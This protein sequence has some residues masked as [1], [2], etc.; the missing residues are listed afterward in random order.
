MPSNT[1]E[2]RESRPERG[3]ALQRDIMLLCNV[4]AGGRWRELANILDSPEARHV[5]WIVT[6]SIKDIGPALGSMGEETKLLCI[7]GGDG[8]I[9]RV[10][11]QMFADRREGPILAFIG[12]GTMNV[13]SSWCGW[14]RK[15]AQNF[16]RV[17][18]AYQSG[19]LLTKE[20]PLL[21][22][23]Q[24]GRTRLGFTFGLGPIVRVLDEYE[25][26][27]KGIGAALEVVVKALS[28]AAFRFPRDYQAVLSP[29]QAEVRKDGEALPYQRFSALFCNTTGKLHVGVEPYVKTR[30]R[31][32]FYF[33]A[34]AVTRQEV[35][36]FLPMLARGRLPLDPKAFMK[37][38]AAWK[39][40][41]LSVIG[42][43][44][45]P[46]DPRYVND[47]AQQVEIRSEEPY[48]TVDAEIVKSTGAPLHV[49]LGPYLQLVVHPTVDLPATVRLAA[50][51]TTPAK[52]KV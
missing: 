29:L 37:P 45:L 21:A 36:L 4:H 25:N 39:Q 34:Y 44:A 51:V 2:P 49:S 33:A 28:G 6:D 26:S 18:K 27:R 52:R 42:Q 22:V 35:A 32:T 23:S 7:Y 47:L 10:L 19:Q 1:P 46:A 15:P 5:R 3:E 43:G 16:R 8:T 24:S 48:Y 50:E 14:G 12:G 31:E 30:T 11:E 13:T 17:V 38:T 9:Q 20:V 41:L 40:I